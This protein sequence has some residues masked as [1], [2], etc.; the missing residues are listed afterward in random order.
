MSALDRSGTLRG[1]LMSG[2]LSALARSNIQAGMEGEQ[3]AGD[4]RACRADRRD[5]LRLSA[6][7]ERD[8]RR[9]QG[10]VEMQIIGSRLRRDGEILRGR[11]ALIDRLTAETASGNFCR[12]LC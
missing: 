10:R 6:D 3:V 2:M 11:R 5:A 4:R 9:R 1:T 7:T 12:G 8:D